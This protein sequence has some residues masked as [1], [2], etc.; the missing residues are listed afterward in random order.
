MYLQNAKSN[1]VVFFINLF[2]HKIKRSEFNNLK[3]QIELIMN[4]VTN[5]LSIIKIML[6]DFNILCMVWLYFFV[7]FDSIKKAESSLC[8]HFVHLKVLNCAI[9]W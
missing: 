3:L 2:N 6:V 5:N 4:H 8:L 7:I 1:F 9:F